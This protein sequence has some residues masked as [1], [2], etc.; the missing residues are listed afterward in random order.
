MVMATRTQRPLWWPHFSSPVRSTA[1]TA[2]LGRVLGIAFGIC[3]VT[4]LLSHYQY[5]PWAWLPVPAAPVWGY[6]LTQGLPVAPG[7][8]CTPLVLVKLWSVSPN[9][10]RFPPL[11]SVRHAVERL[12][13][14]VLVA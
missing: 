9:L 13:V 11:R 8:A 2:R 6:R 14:A 1:L 12:S 10:F 7:I 5:H 4:G 3:F